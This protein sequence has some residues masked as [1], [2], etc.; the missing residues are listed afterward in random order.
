[1]TAI[2]VVLL[3]QIVGIVLVIA[4]LSIPAAAASRF[5]GSLLRMMMGATL[6]SMLF[7]VSGLALS[8]APRLHTGATII[9]VAAVGYGVTLLTV[10]YLRQLKKGKINGT[11]RLTNPD[12]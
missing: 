8:Y 7:M 4:L 5:S 3:T 6:L 10:Y 9:Q 11:T 12:D 1:M 2:T